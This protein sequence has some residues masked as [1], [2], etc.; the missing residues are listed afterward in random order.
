MTIQGSGGTEDEPHTENNIEPIRPVAEATEEEKANAKPLGEFVPPTL[1]ERL[2][3]ET[4]WYLTEEKLSATHD[5]SIE[6]FEEFHREIKRLRLQNMVAMDVVNNYAS[7]L[8]VLSRDHNKLAQIYNK[9]LED[10]N[11]IVR[12][13]KHIRYLQKQRND[14]SPKIIAPRNTRL[15]I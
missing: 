1:S 4:E 12:L 3:Q 8:Q 14:A 10:T 2:S 15:I 11:D 6:Q 5:G 13:Q 9:L 7:K